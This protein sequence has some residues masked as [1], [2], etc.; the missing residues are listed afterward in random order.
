MN[1]YKNIVETNLANVGEL[2]HV[3]HDCETLANYA[4]DDFQDILISAIELLETIDPIGNDALLHLQDMQNEITNNPTYFS[5]L[6]EAIKAQRLDS[7][8]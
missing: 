6:I 3:S 2:N 8:L 1:N 5:V 7:I 4:L